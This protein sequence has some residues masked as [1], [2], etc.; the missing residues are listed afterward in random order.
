M[1]DDTS[2]QIL[3]ELQKQSRIGKI[4]LVILV[5]LACTVMYLEKARS[6]PPVPSWP[7]VKY[8]LDKKDYAK[9]LQIAQT[10]VGNQTNDNYG[11]GYLGTIYRLMGDMENAKIHFTRAYELYPSEVNEKNLSA[12]RKAL[13][14]KKQQASD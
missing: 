3:E 5:F 6:I 7:Q 1:E 14:A 8:A 13:E 9:A 4:S 11:E 12:I 10:L 2:R